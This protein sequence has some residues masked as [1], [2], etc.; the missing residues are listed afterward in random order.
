MWG[1]APREAREEKAWL[2]LQV[3]SSSW[4]QTQEFTFAVQQ[5]ITRQQREINKQGRKELVRGGKWSQQQ[6]HLKEDEISSVR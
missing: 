3:Y 1:H 6:A 4:N 2:Q 5:V